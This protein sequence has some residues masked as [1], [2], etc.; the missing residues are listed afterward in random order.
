MRFHW[1][2]AEGQSAVIG[3]FLEPSENPVGL[4]VVPRTARDQVNLP[5]TWAVSDEKCAFAII[6]LPV[7]WEDKRERSKLILNTRDLGD[8]WR[9]SP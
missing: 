3:M 2:P 5:A 8:P 4:D 1:E 6:E 7:V 9:T